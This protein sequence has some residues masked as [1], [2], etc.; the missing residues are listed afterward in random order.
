MN[1]PKDGTGLPTGRPEQQTGRPEQGGGCGRGLAWIMPGV[2]VCMLLVAGR[3][4]TDSVLLTR[5]DFRGDP[6]MPARM[7]GSWQV[8]PARG[9]LGRSRGEPLRPVAME[10]KDLWQAAEHGIRRL[11]EISKQRAWGR[12]DRPSQHFQRNE[13]MNSAYAEDNLSSQQAQQ[14]QQAQQSQQH[15]RLAE[16]G[17]LDGSTETMGEGS[18]L[19]RIRNSVQGIKDEL[20]NVEAEVKSLIALDS[21]R[22]KKIDSVKEKPMVEEDRNGEN[23]KMNNINKIKSVI[24]VLQKQVEQLSSSSSSSSSKRQ[25]EMSSSAQ[26]DASAFASPAAAAPPRSA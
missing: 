20:R 13:D 4:S 25:L 24:D 15:M 17:G 8:T 22:A 16:H 23:D 12:R 6:T 1:T 10:G 2:I 14:A 7:D 3:D 9:F 21:P 19:G 26:P 11:E 18:D 5:R